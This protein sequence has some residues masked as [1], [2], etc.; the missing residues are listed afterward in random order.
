MPDSGERDQD[1]Q[2]IF[3]S[4]PNGVATI[5]SDGTIGRANTQLAGM[6]G[7]APSELAGRPAILLFPEAKRTELSAARDELAS[8]ASARARRELPG[9][10]KDGSEF[11]VE[12]ALTAFKG[13][14][15]TSMLIVVD[16]T[17]RK[18]AEARQDMLIG[19]LH[20]RTQNIF[21]VIQSVATRTLDGRRTLEEA[22]R[23]F[24]NRLHALARTYTVLTESAWEGAQLE[25]ILRDELA[26]FSGRFEFDGCPLIVQPSAAQTFAMIFHE[27]ATN[28]SKYGAL[29]LPSGR[30]VIGWRVVQADAELEFRFAWSEIDG[31]RVRPPRRKGYGRT[32]LEDGARHIGKPTIEYRPDGLRYALAA[33][34]ASI[35]WLPEQAPRS[36]GRRLAGQIPQYGGTR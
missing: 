13:S 30:L 21:A 3:E 35:G 23:V 15:G 29:S 34:L 25:T 18:Q 33:P 7:Y 12:I 27:L 8:G 6:F 28:A 24:L 31:P 2:A 11:P 22:R 17:A 20:H 19:E 32:I 1:I 14:A 9:L 4:A 16:M 26:G 36:S 10:R 5:A